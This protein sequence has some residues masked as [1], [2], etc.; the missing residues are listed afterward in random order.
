VF[1]LLYINLTIIEI[2]GV[3]PEARAEI[4]LPLGAGI[5]I[6]DSGSGSNSFSL[7]QT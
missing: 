2:S 5:E 7:P 4:K 3:K 1:E 6:T